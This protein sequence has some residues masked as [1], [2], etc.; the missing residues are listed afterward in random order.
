MCQQLTMGLSQLSSD[1]AFG[2]TQRVESTPSHN[3]TSPAFQ[4]PSPRH[5][6]ET[7]KQDQ[8]DECGKILFS[9]TFIKPISPPQIISFNYIEYFKSFNI[10]LYLLTNDKIVKND[11]VRLIINCVNSKTVNYRPNSQLTL[12]KWKTMV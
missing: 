1:D 9:L 12:L 4:A 11:M 8:N 6:N 10:W 7:S 5:T 2:T 3:L